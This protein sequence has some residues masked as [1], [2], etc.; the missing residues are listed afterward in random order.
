ML[1]SRQKYNNPL[2]IP[3]VIYH[4][5]YTRNFW[6][7]LW[8]LVYNE[9]VKAS[10]LVKHYFCTITTF[11]WGV[12]GQILLQVVESCWGTLWQR[13]RCN[14]GSCG[15]DQLF[16]PRGA[17][18]HRSLS[19]C[20]SWWRRGLIRCPGCQD[21]SWSTKQ[22]AKPTTN[23]YVLSQA[24]ATALELPCCQMRK[25]SCL[26]VCPVWISGNLFTCVRLQICSF[27]CKHYLRMSNHF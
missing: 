20:L 10:Y 6:W 4:L 21:E 16:S 24:A 12:R 1:T 18:C 2:W 15:L 11:T 25:P 27:E 17:P 7:A 8:T 26:W 19:S 5:F 3:H 22:R 13:W 14:I 9:T 23:L